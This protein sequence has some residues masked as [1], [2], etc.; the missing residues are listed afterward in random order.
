MFATILG[1][2]QGHWG[3]LAITIFGFIEWGC[4]IRLYDN[5]TRQPGG[6]TALDKIWLAS[7]TFTMI[8]SFTAFL[9][10]PVVYDLAP[11]YIPNIKRGLD[12]VGD[13]VAGLWYFFQALAELLGRP[14]L[15]AR[16]GWTADH[17]DFYATAKVG[18]PFESTLS[19][20]GSFPPVGIR[21]DDLVT[22]PPFLEFSAAD[23]WEGQNLTVHLNGTPTE[24]K[25]YEFP[26]LVT[27]SYD[28]NNPAWYTFHLHVE[29]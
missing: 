25:D 15:W 1:K 5:A 14:S 21:L 10:L 29:K 3:Q 2:A 11:E 27:N 8:S 12:V 24:V 22:A 26:V 13:V 7:Q 19:A 23:P 9:R 20:T 6:P 28:P 18:Q 4:S 17:R 16:S